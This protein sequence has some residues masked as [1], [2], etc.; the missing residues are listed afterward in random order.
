MKVNYEKT[1]EVNRELKLNVDEQEDDLKQCDID[2]EDGVQEITV[3]RTPMRKNRQVC[4]T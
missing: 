3:A 1:I 4:V 2:D